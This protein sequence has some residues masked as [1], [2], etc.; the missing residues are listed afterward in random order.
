MTLIKK[1]FLTVVVA[2]VLFAAQPALAKN[3]SPAEEAV[4]GVGSVLGS[5]IYAPAKMVYAVLGTVVGGGA[6]L[7]TGGNGKV[8]SPIINN[9]VRGDYVITPSHLKG[10]RELRF[11]G[12]GRR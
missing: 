11:V 6:Y 4:V 10:E 8:A 1:R 2:G 9:A 12:D 3:E 5:V 7:L